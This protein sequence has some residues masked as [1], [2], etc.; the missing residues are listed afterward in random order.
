MWTDYAEIGRLLV[1]VA[2]DGR[3]VENSFYPVVRS[4]RI[5][6]LPFSFREDADFMQAEIEATHRIFPESPHIVE[7][8]RPGDF[9]IV[10]DKIYRIK[11]KKNFGDQIHFIVYE[12]PEGKQEKAEIRVAAAYQF[13]VT[14]G[15]YSWGSSPF[16]N[17]VAQKPPFVALTSVVDGEAYIASLDSTGMTI[18]D[19]GIGQPFQGDVVVWNGEYQAIDRWYVTGLSAGSYT[20]GY[21]ALL[22]VPKQS[23][24]PFVMAIPTNDGSCYV[25]SITQHGFRIVDRGVGQP[26]QCNVLILQDTSLVKNRHIFHNV[27]PG[28]Y[29]FG[30]GIL[31]SVKGLFN[32]PIILKQDTK[33]GQT[34]LANITDTGFSIIDRNIGGTAECSLAIITI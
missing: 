6:L 19:R 12:G 27:A 31:S 21:H 9:Y 20:F 29:E 26:V 5:A 34:Y 10:N 15:S 13:N 4:H 11:A 16:S 1:S 17:I 25:D 8:A 24:P 14:A 7:S 3:A 33:D 23:K 30:K 2:P 22:G 18:V 32:R 28:N